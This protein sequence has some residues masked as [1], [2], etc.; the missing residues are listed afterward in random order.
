MRRG[1]RARRKR[2]AL[3]ADIMQC[4]SFLKVCPSADRSHDLEPMIS[5]L[6]RHSWLFWTSCFTI[7]DTAF[8]GYV[9]SI[10]DITHIG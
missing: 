3:D 10:A 7:H 2:V 4:D 8:V 1:F 5:N 9:L 6:L